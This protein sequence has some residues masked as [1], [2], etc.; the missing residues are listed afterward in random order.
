MNGSCQ[1]PEPVLCGCCEGIGDETPE[2]IYNRPGLSAVSYRVGTHNTFL[3]S[4]LADLSSSTEPALAGLRTR[5][6]SDF[7]I[8]LLDAWAICLDILS[9]YQERIV[10]E[11]YLRTAVDSASVF[12][13]AQ[14]VGYTP[15]PG[16]AASAFLAFTLNSAPGS[17]DNVLIPAGTRVQSVPLPGQQPQVFE[18]SSDITALIEQNAIPAATTVPWGL[19]NLDTLMWLQG[20]NNNINVGDGILF[21]SQARY[22]GAASG[23]TSAS[24]GA[25]F[26]IVT[27]VTL[28]STSGNT[29][30]VWDQPLQ[31]LAENDNTAHVYVFRKKAS[32]F[33]VQ[34]PDPR[35][36]FGSATNNNLSNLTGWPTDGNGDWTFQDGYSPGSSLINLDASYPGAAPQN[37]VPAWI[38]LVSPDFTVLYQIMTAMDTGPVLYTLTTKTTQLTLANP[39]TLATNITQ[40]NNEV[41]VAEAVVNPGLAA[42]TRVA[43]LN[44]RS[45]AHLQALLNGPPSPDQ[46]LQDFVRLTRSTTAYVQSASLTPTDPPYGAP[47][48]TWPYANTYQPQA[49]MLTPVE[50]S[51]LEL[52][53][54]EQL[55]G[56]QQV[57]V[58][59]QRVRLQVVATSSQPFVGEP[60]F[61]PNGATGSLG[62]SNGQI[63]LIDAFPPTAAT[64]GSDQLWSVITTDGVAG[65]LTI[66]AANVLLVA[67]DKN[68]PVAG[69]SATISQ[70][71]VDGP[72]VTLAFAQPLS[73]I[74]DRGGSKPVT[75]NANVT[76]ATQGETMNE[77]MGSGDATNPA[78]QF[79]LKQSPLTY[80]SSPLGNGAVST[81]QVWVNNLRWH[82]VDNFLD[83]VPTDRVFITQADANQNVTVQF[84]D[85]G[86]GARPPTGQMNIRAVY[87]KG[88]GSAGNVQGGQLSQALDRPQGL[89]GVTNPD[90]AA[91]GADPDTAAAARASAP[92]HVLTLDRVVS[93]ED[94]QNFALAFAGIAKAL[95]TWTWSGRARGVFLTVAGANG[96]VFQPDDLTLTNLKSALW[97]AGNPYVPIQVVSYIPVMFEAGANILIDQTNYDPKQVLAQVWQSLAAAFGFGQRQI[98]QG[99]AQS[100]IIALIQQTPGVIAVQLRAFNRQGQPPPAGAPLPAVLRAAA[101]VAGQT[102]VPSGAEMLLIDPA[103]QPSFEVWS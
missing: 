76:A 1:S 77:I 88:T 68:D 84:G 51:Q 91:G 11:S 9:F 81:L 19:N 3:A 78:L 12:A 56:G 79:I 31:W 67:A 44:A 21:V 99:V 23:S 26:H 85:G 50:G 30:V 43:V 98:G 94:Y 24:G 45:Q 90:P 52:V 60:G 73:R 39:L 47:Y 48:N 6:P 64:N 2:L 63:F 71:S 70:V 96:D 86:E 28:D 87:R 4:L 35:T 14:L 49:G 46:I 65:T 100:E 103:S 29:L 38:V 57:A 58:S 25:D 53:G 13:L 41:T 66:A 95:A 36:L 92:L 5:D 55:T 89:S 32:L 83:S 16:V 61:V 80:V 8:A 27:S 40:L 22:S 93:L 59:G 34:A 54:G 33:G 20:T 101:P 102:P 72:I 15:S 75:C 97:N 10:N 17:P 74:Y 18:T 37:G 42:L 82:E 69:E 62:L 7:S